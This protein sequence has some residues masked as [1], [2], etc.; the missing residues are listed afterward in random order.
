MAEY[1]FLTEWRLQAPKS[2]VFDAISETHTWP[3]WWEGVERVEDIEPGDADGIGTVKRYTWKSASPYRIRFDARTTHI[4]KGVEIAAMVIGDLAGG[5]RW[6]FAEEGDVTIVH[7]LWQ[8][9]TEKLWM[10]VI[11]P[12]ARPLFSRNHHLLMEQGA[13]GLAGHLQ[14]KLIG[15]VHTDGDAV[16][17]VLE[18]V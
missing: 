14:A 10:N 9:R 16:Q 17:K 12:L 7:Y 2:E 4:V 3:Q 6:I 8:V 1:R 11:A 15:V 13:R 5:G 18:L